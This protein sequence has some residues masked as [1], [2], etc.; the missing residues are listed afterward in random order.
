VWAP[1]DQRFNVVAPDDEQVI[2]G[3]AEARERARA[4]ARQL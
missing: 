4:L 1:G 3:Y 2:V